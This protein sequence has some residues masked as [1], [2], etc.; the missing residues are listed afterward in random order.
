LQSQFGLLRRV[1]T[2]NGNLQIG[3]QTVRFGLP[4]A[5][6]GNSTPQPQE[7][8]QGRKDYLPESF[9]SFH[10]REAEA[11]STSA[12]MRSVGRELGPKRARIPGILPKDR[13]QG[14]MSTKELA[15]VMNQGEPQ[16]GHNIS[17]V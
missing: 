15:F 1:A 12:R 7:R 4:V 6:A 11:D 2:E 14:K 9:L 16:N 10:R 3:L 5:D 17:G 13:Q 8:A